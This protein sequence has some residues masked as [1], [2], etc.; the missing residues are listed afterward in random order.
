M[1]LRKRPERCRRVVSQ[2]TG[3][4]LTQLGGLDGRPGSGDL[5]GSSVLNRV[6]VGS[7]PVASVDSEVRAPGT[8]VERAVGTERNIVLVK[9]VR[10]EEVAGLV[11]TIGCR[12]G[13]V[14]L[15]LSLTSSGA[16]SGVVRVIV[17]Q[18]HAVVCVVAVVERSVNGSGKADTSLEV[19]NR[20]KTL[21]SLGVTVGASNDNVESIAAGILGT[22]PLALVGSSR[23]GNVVTVNGTL[24]V[25]DRLRVGAA[26]LGVVL[27]VTLVVDVETLAVLLRVAEGSAVRRRVRVEV[28]VGKVT[29]LLGATGQVLEGLLVA[30]GSGSSA[31][32]LPQFAFG[33]KVSRGAAVTGDR[34]TTTGQRSTAAAHIALLYDT[35]ILDNG[36]H[37]GSGNSGVVGD[38]SSL[39]LLD[40]GPKD[41]RSGNSQSSLNVD[42]LRSSGDSAEDGGGGSNVTHL[43]GWLV[44][45]IDR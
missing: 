29:D 12:V 20:G 21:A 41:G 18:P 7:V 15:G 23:S 22:A 27:G 26:V 32:S 4:D 39:G 25:G 31:G 30:R 17:E 38:R 37:G 3:Y 19:R 14:V 2:S 35:L 13:D 1:N 42:H 28:L 24:D 11:A 16:E 44:G 5:V 9:D 6:L 33:V 8:S 36:S 45:E 34:C 40:L 43:D 10:G